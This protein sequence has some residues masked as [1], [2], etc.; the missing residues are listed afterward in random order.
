MRRAKANTNWKLAVDLALASVREQPRVPLKHEW[1]KFCQD[2]IEFLTKLSTPV[3]PE[4]VFVDKLIDFC[5]SDV[6][7]LVQCFL[8]CTDGRE[9]LPNFMLL[10]TFFDKSI[11]QGTKHNSA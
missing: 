11:D 4:S 9:L 2:K 10:F 7:F 1:K 3:V 5:R 8:A 6:N